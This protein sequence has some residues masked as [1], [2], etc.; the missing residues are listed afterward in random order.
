MKTGKRRK[1]PSKPITLSDEVWLRNSKE[2]TTYREQLLK[3]QGNVCPITLEYME[4]GVLDHVHIEGIGLD[5]QVRGVL[6]Q[7]ANLLEGYFLK[8]FK[9]FK[10][11]ENCGADF[12]TFL[13]RLGQYLQQDRTGNPL[14]F[15]YMDEMRKK[16]QRKTIPVLLEMLESDFNITANKTTSKRDLVQLYIQN[17]VH[18]VEI[19]YFKEN[20]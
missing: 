18:E 10:V 19:K 3:G 14:H 17:W 15:K 1:S 7:K 4:S 11:E 2:I 12:P 8:I 5:G 9:R 20:T 16:V 13:I 6:S